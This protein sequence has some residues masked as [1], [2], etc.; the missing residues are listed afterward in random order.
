MF[1]PRRLMGPPVP[2]RLVG[3]YS[4]LD[5]RFDTW[6]YNRGCFGVC[7]CFDQPCKNRGDWA[8]CCQ[9]NKIKIQPYRR[10]PTPARLI[11]YVTVEMGISPSKWCWSGGGR[12]DA[13]QA[14]HQL[15]RFIQEYVVQYG[16]AKQARV[17]FRWAGQ[18]WME[19]RP[20]RRVYKACLVLFSESPSPA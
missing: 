1:R 11:R 10:K 14:G 12:T 5:A 13:P 6:D 9:R 3:G 20:W 19:T 16:R 17:A 15:A 4:V 7:R 18:D 2:L 8:L